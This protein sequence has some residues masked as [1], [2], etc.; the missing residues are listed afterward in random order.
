[1]PF[2]Q[3]LRTGL[4]GVGVSLEMVPREDKKPHCGFL[5]EMNPLQREWG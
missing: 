3:R 1:M 2:T 5:G 4:P